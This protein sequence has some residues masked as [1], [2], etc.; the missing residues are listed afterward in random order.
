[1]TQQQ[2]KQ[3]AH[4]AWLSTVMPHN[5]LSTACDTLE[6]H[7]V[8]VGLLQLLT[9][10]PLSNFTSDT[11]TP[12]CLRHTQRLVHLATLRESALEQLGQ[13]DAVKVSLTEKK[14][15]QAGRLQAA[16]EARLATALAA[17]DPHR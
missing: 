13:L 16:L 1:M 11:T 15:T 6:L 12:L 9:T 3:P 2:R 5:N 8:L 17:V 10:P 14:A 4:D 7:K